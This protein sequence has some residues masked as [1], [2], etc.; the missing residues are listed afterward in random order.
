MNYLGDGGAKTD[1]SASERRKGRMNKIIKSISATEGDLY[2]ISAGERLP[3]A[4]FIGWVKTTENTKLTLSP[5]TVE[6]GIKTIHA[7]L[8]VC[9]HLEY[10]REIIN[11]FIRAGK[12]F[13]AYADIEGERFYFAGLRF[14]NF[15]HPQNELVFEIADLE[16]I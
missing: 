4:R 11:K 9:V 5:G 10:K 2:V 14:E 7:S 16:L 1:Q 3:L 12:V 6:E 8:T 13:E 15:N